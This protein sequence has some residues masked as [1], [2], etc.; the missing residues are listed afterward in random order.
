MIIFWISEVPSPMR[1]IGAPAG[2]SGHVDPADLDA[3]HHLVQAL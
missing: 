3:V 1:S 2:A